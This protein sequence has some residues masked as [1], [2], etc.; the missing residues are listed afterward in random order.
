ME[1]RRRGFR[2]VALADD[3]FYPVTAAD[4]AMAARRRDSAEHERLSALRQERFELMRH[5]A[6]LAG[7]MVFITQSTMEGA[8]DPELLEAMRHARIKG[9]LVGVEAVTREGLKDIHKGLNIPTPFK[10]ASNVEWPMRFVLRSAIFAVALTGAASCGGSGS[11][12]TAP[13]PVPATQTQTSLPLP[14]GQATAGGGVPCPP[15]GAAGTTCSGL[16]VACPSVPGA[17]ATLGITRPAATALNRGT[18]VLTT[19]GDGTNFRDS[20]LTPAMISTLVADGLVVVQVAWDPPG[21]WGGPQARTLACRYATVAKWIYEN[22][23]T[24]GRSELF[25]AQGTSGGAGQIAFGLGF[26]GVPDFLDLANL[27][28]GPPQC[29]LCSSDGQHSFEPLLPFQP[30]SS[31]LPLLNYPATTV[32]FF[33]GDHDPNSNGTADF[34]R[35]YHDAITSAKSFTTVPNT[36]H[37]VEST[38]AGVDAYVASVRDALK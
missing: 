17:S 36:P 30:E 21:I 12:P 34:A 22:V 29:P 33:L 31:P 19:G 15:G 8:E 9:A 38:H 16:V 27:G 2:F 3:N 23:H 26:Y 20:P 10:G 28:G 35:T 37:V 5:L 4:L 18:I 25:A 13:T 24:G 32:R 7:D 6:E 11:S 14:Y 1:L